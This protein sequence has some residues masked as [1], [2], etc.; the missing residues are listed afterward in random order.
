MLQKVAYSVEGTAGGSGFAQPPWDESTCPLLDPVIGFDRVDD[1]LK[2]DDARRRVDLTAR[3]LMRH[4]ERIRAG[5]TEAIHL[6]VVCSAELDLE[7]FG[8][9]SRAS[10]GSMVIL[11]LQAPYFLAYRKGCRVIC[12]AVAGRDLRAR[13]KGPDGQ[14]LS[15][16]LPKGAGR[17]VTSYVESLHANGCDLVE[18][19]ELVNDQL[20]ELL[21]QAVREQ[22]RG[23]ARECPVERLLAAVR[24]LINDEI[25]NPALSSKLIC[26]RLEISRSKLFEVL[27]R[28][29]T[30]LSECIRQ[31]R[32]RRVCD[33]L[34]DPRLGALTV[35]DIARRWGYDD[36]ASFGRAF[37]KAYGTPPGTFRG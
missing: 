12:V 30:S 24:S 26:H 27:A 36:P 6:V 20:V 18:A 19:T 34:K 25:A 11:D 7:Q 29:G 16:I 13:L 5:A 14:P 9:T 31:E 4:P 17:L 23:H 37:K 35:A 32:L 2:S 33:D 21:V 22:T 28:G 1:G 15:L 3:T 10:A 8:R